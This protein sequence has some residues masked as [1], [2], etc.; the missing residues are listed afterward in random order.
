MVPLA[1]IGVYLIWGSTYYG[2][3][4]AL[5]GFPPFAMAAI[6]FLIAGGLMARPDKP[7][8]SYS[9][10]DYLDPPTPYTFLFHIWTG[11]TDRIF[12]YANY[13]RIRRTVPTTL[14]GGARG[15]SMMAR[16]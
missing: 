6:R 5:G 8:S 11:G 15:F 16:R 9:Y 7:Y 2:L 10:E 4:V 13:E 1:L 14:M 12:R 3:R